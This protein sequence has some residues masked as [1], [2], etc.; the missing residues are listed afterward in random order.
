M[1]EEPKVY[2][3]KIEEIITKFGYRIDLESSIPSSFL[4]K[5]KFKLNKIFNLNLNVNYSIINFIAREWFFD[6]CDFPFFYIKYQFY[7]NQIIVAFRK[8]TIY[9]DLS[10]SFYISEDPT[11]IKDDIARVESFISSVIDLK[12]IR[13]SNNLERLCQD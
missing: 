9:H 6:S 10:I 13:R 3:R 12:S 4:E 7:Y 8:D 2:T 5:F 11:E 1:Q